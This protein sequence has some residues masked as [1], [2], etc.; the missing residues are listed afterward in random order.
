ML[1]WDF[2][3][4]V[5]H[6]SLA[7]AIA[8]LYATGQWAGLWLDWH[9]H[10]GAFVLALMVFRA[11]WGFVGSTHA[12]F[13]S[14][15]P[16]PARWRAFIAA[17]EWEIGHSPPAALSIF[18]LVSGTFAVAAT[19]LFARNDDVDFHGPLYDLVSSRQS[20]TL[21]AWHACV[22]DALAALI[23]MHLLAI[24]YYAAFRSKNLLLPMVTGKVIL[25]DARGIAP[26]RRAP[27]RHALLAVS[28][29]A[30]T[31][32]SIESGALRILLLALQRNFAS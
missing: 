11:V 25:A 1:V 22:F 31:L 15:F 7:L 9:A 13:A 26:I 29:A 10:L 23:G 5:F 17:R 6:W 16:T 27:A 28:M 21:T 4:R 19:G 18:A 12:R 32:W 14:F 2:P 8:A 30:I 20:E 24:G 3:L